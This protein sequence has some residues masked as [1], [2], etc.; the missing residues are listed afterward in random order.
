[1]QR[2][3][4]LVV[5]TALHDVLP[6][7]ALRLAQRSNIVNIEA[8]PFD[9]D[10]YEQEELEY[11][12]ETGNTRVRV[13]STIRWRHAPGPDGEQRRQSNARFVRWS[14][15]SLQLMVGEEVLD[16]KEIDLRGD[17]NYL[18]ARWPGL[19]QVGGGRGGGH[20]PVCRP[21]SCAAATWACLMRPVAGVAA[22]GAL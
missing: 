8:R 9:P 10:S 13:Q 6:A 14:D 17:H 1:M 2:A 4:P 19:L 7:A 21:A 16:V 15:G 22:C 12:D 11:I 18:Y 20:R 5:E 3:P